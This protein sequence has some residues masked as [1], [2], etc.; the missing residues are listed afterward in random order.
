MCGMKVTGDNIIVS[1]KNP[2]I[3]FVRRDGM[4]EIHV[5]AIGMKP[6]RFLF[7]PDGVVFIDENTFK[8]EAV[9]NHEG[10]WE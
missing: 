5:S 6:W 8:Y 7:K 2:C 10:S 3:A 9:E 4:V 1:R